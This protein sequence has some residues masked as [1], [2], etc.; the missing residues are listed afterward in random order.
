MVL[1]SIRQKEKKV[2]KHILKEL[3][4]H[5]GK[6]KWEGGE[7]L[8]KNLG[9]LIFLLKMFFRKYKIKLCIKRIMHHY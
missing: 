2:T 4:I 7:E 5:G 8:K 3:Y 1:E 9:S 6:L